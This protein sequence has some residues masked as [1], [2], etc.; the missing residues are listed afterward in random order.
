MNAGEAVPVAMVVI[1]VL[2]CALLGASLIRP[3]L[4]IYALLGL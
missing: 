2:L 3:A 1:V 4:D